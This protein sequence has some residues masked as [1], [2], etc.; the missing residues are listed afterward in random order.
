MEFLEKVRSGISEGW[1]KVVDF[2]IDESEEDTRPSAHPSKKEERKALFD[3][4]E[5]DSEEKPLKER[6]CA[7]KN[8]ACETVRDAKEKA[9][10]C[11]RKRSGREKMAL[12]FVCGLLLGA[13][14]K[15]LANNKI[16]IGYRDYTAKSGT[17]DFI[18]L[19]KKVAAEG[20]SAA[21][22]GGGIPGGGGSCAQ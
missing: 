19:Q 3:E 11:W 10:S 2:W 20:G 17:Y 4:E 13:G 14:V 15:M 16:T 7:L 21:I 18:D 22:T 6:L 12:L 9:V 8:K 1:K 5:T